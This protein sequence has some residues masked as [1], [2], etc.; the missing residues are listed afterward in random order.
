MPVF[1]ATLLRERFT[2]SEALPADMT[3]KPPLVA[4]SNRINLSLLSP[5]QEQENFVIRAQNM[6]NCARMAARVA[7]EFQENGPLINRAQPFDWGDAYDSINNKYEE[8]W[9]PLFWISAYHQGRILYEN[10]N[11][12]RH[13]FLDIIEQC[14][15]RNKSDYENSIDIARDAFRQAGKMV[16]IEYYSNIAL[17]VNVETHEGRCG[18]ILRGPNK[19]TTFNFTARKKGE[20]AIKPSQCLNL[21]A[22]YLEA[23]QLS[24]LI[25]MLRKKAKY[26][27]IGKAGDEA[28][29]LQDATQR[30]GRLKNAIS[31]LESILDIS[32]RPERPNM[33]EMIA[34]AEAYAEKSLSRLLREKIE[35]GEANS[36]EWID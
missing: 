33:N 34:S 29:Q 19:T 4:L 26:E 24:F 18:V 5:K 17:V 25:G 10:G 11:G 21:C 1:N 3:D 13:P 7:L 35:S 23:I 9:N 20:N 28:K 2:I 12:S 16:N 30:L 8:K 27:L 15:A 36:G 6:H 14:D 31:Q 32:Y 22:S